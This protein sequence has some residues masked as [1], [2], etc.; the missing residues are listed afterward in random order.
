MVRRSRHCLLGVLLL[1]TTGYADN[2]HKAQWT[3]PAG[4]VSRTSNDDEIMD[5]GS[6]D[7]QMQ[8][9]IR[10]PMAVVIGNCRN[11]AEGT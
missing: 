8:G 2:A 6:P 1:T 9:A 10:R 5:C 4:T 3:A 11:T 7:V